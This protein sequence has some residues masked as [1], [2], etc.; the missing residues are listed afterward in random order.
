MCGIAGWVGRADTNGVL[1]RVA[2]MTRSLAHR[3]PDDG[4]VMELGTCGD[5]R[6]V[7]GHR[8]LAILD[9]SPLGRQPMRSRSAPVAIALNGEV[10]NFRE[11]RSEL[12]RDGSAFVSGS[13]TEVVLESFV[14][15]IASV[16]ELRG[17]FAFA[18]WDERTGELWLARDTVGI[19]PLYYRVESGGIAFASELRALAG[20]GATIDAGSLRRFVLHGYVP[21]A[22]TIL[23]SHRN[24]D[25][26]S[27]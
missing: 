18:V 15:G 2:V 14:R 1:E 10:Y 5:H 19:K 3:G 12:E 27:N 24:D 11:L 16:S 22:Q 26:H 13:D 6:A 4:A 9:P 20:T 25:Q 7:F 17:M 8:R 21:G 23:P